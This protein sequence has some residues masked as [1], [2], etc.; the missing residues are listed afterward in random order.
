MSRPQA[1]RAV[2]IAKQN[3]LTNAHLDAIRSAGAT[4]VGRA[5]ATQTGTGKNT[6]EIQQLA[7][8]AKEALGGYYREFLLTTPATLG[9]RPTCSCPAHEPRPGRVLDPFCGSGRVGIE[10]L[11]LGLDFT[12]V[13][14]SPSYCDMANRL[15]RSESPLFS[16]V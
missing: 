3:G 6:D 12:G 8:E 14:L 5:A 15:L 13:E 11:R 10:C 9:W 2:E 4:D 7:A 16:G 1:K